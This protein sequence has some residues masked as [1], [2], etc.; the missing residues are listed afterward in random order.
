[1]MKLFGFAVKCAAS[2]AALGFVACSSS[3]TSSD[4]VAGGVTDIGNSIAYTGSVQ[5][6]SGN[7]V[8]LA[9]VVA[10]YDSWEQ[11]A[12]VDSVETVTNDKGEFEIQVDSG[13]TFVLYA[14]ADDDC[15]LAK[16][17]ASAQNQTISIGSKKRL[18]GSMYGKTGGYM[19]V[20]G[21]G[22]KAQVGSDGSFK[23]DA[24]PPGDISLVYMDGE[25]SRARLEFSTV[26]AEDSLNIPALDNASSADWLVI[27]DYR[28]Y[29]D[30]HFGGINV[31]VPDNMEVPTE[32]K[33]EGKD[34]PKDDQWGDRDDHGDRKPASAQLKVNVP[35]FSADAYNFIVPVKFS[36]RGFNR[37]SVMVV[38]GRGVEMG[39][40]LDYWNDSSAVLWVR[41]DTLA[42]GVTELS[43][44]VQQG[45]SSKFSFFGIGMPNVLASIHMSD[46]VNVL[47]HDF[48]NAGSPKDKN[49]FIGDG[50]T[51]EAGQFID[52]SYLDP[53]MGDFTMSLWTKWKGPNG[54]HQVL[55]SQRAY[56]SDSTSRFQWHFEGSRGWFTVMKSSP[57]Y[58]EAVYFGDSSIVP[59]GEW[60]YLTLVSKDH[61]VTMYVN[62]EPIEFVDGQGHRVT[63][64]EFIPNDLNQPV[65]FRIGGDEIDGET[66]NGAIDEIR[67]DAA[68]R[69]AE[70]VKASYETQKAVASGK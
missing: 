15:G 30:S 31:F 50:V 53:C 13:A 68:A 59:V 3:G 24:L 66:W 62:G 29:R 52:M 61:M 27:T 26:D 65:P 10:Y 22:M 48:S 9:R 28:Y 20:V 39:Y 56:W 25:Q 43:V 55:F 58:P 32:P 45:K 2:L 44:N 33:D 60:A 7:P 49:G 16:F 4:E 1:M 37:D 47:N 11:T 67:I 14:S 40:E 12:I 6:A 51:L 42:A 23:F 21:S 41:I 18:S 57:R 35:A 54:H 5:D 19:R 69:D 8:A 46:Y 70:W 17:D 34:Y 36:T 63:A 38:D 64:Q